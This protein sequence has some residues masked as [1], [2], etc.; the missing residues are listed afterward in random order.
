MDDKF[1]NVKYGEYAN[2]GEYYD[3]YY[4]SATTEDSLHKELRKINDQLLEDKQNLDYAHSSR[5]HNKVDPPTTTTTKSTTRYDHS[6]IFG[7]LY[8]NYVFAV[9][10]TQHTR[11]FDKL[12]AIRLDLTFSV[13]F[14]IRQKISD[15]ALLVPRHCSSSRSNAG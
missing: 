8:E 4:D 15:I 7:A 14:G 13:A 5:I 9:F 12:R 10:D 3:E 1:G 2:G 11:R 6:S